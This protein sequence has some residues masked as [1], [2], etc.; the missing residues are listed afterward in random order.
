MPLFRYAFQNYDP[1]LHIRASG[2]EVDVSPKTARE[3]CKAINGMLLNDAKEYLES[4]KEK[5]A[6]VPFRRFKRGSAHRSDINGFHAGAYPV[7]AA[8]KVLEV[9]SN[10]E[11]NAEFKGR[12]LD[13]MKIIHAAALRGRLVRAYT[14]R[15]QGRSSPSF[16][17]LVHIE[18]VAT[19]A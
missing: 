2:R 6:P 17:T 18:L 12:D 5:R 11:A 19:E 9:V 7:K 10:L 14:P 4:V 3:V 8:T 16:N 13:R 15:A 1:L